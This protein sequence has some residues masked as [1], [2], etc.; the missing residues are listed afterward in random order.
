M[1]KDIQNLRPTTIYAIHASMNGVYDYWQKYLSQYVTKGA[2]L[3]FTRTMLV[4]ETKCSAKAYDD[5]ADDLIAYRRSIASQSLIGEER[6]P[7]PHI[8]GLARKLRDLERSILEQVEPQQ[9]S[10]S[11]REGGA[12]IYVNP[13]AFRDN[14]PIRY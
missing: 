11:Q 1:L 10:L 5:A 7:S 6:E 13:D 2:E 9:S 4:V 8:F 3:S 14:Q 12:V